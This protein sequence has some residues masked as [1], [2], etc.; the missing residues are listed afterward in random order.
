M[1]REVVRK[2][3]KIDANQT[4]IVKALRQAGAT[5]QSLAAAGGG[6]PDLLVGFQRKTVLIEIKDG[7]KKPSA[8]EL[9]TDQVE[10]HLNWRGGPCMVVNSVGEALAAI[11]IE[12]QP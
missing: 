4:E 10:W 6:V 3:G 7:S 5:V 1:K 12:V 9:T 8:R 2:R 11:G